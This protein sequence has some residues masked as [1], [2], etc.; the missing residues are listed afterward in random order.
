M[1]FIMRF[2][3]AASLAGAAIAAPA[4]PTATDT[5]D[6]Y[7]AQATARTSSPT[8]HVKGK[9][10]D[11]Y[12][13]IWFEN[14]DFD[15]AAA[16][17]N[18]QFFAEK[19]ITLTNNLALT[20]PSEP[21]YMA[22]VGGDYFG[23]DGDPFIQVPQNVSSVVD[24]LEDKGIS[25]SLYQEDMPYTGFE[26]FAWVNQQ[27]GANDYVRKHNP[28]I[29]YNSV[30]TN[31]DRL[32]NIK[33]TT[34]FYEDLKANKL[35]QWMFITPN[36][37]S[38]GHD[39]SVTVAGQWLRTFLEPLL[40]DKNFMQNTMVLI[41]FDE[42]ETYTIQNRVF[43]VLLG[44][45]VPQELVGTTDSNYYNHYSEISTVEANW[46]LYTLGRWDVGANVFSNV[47]A[48][49]GDR[50]RCW[51]AQPD[52]EHRYFN[53]SYSGIFNS[54]SFAVQPVPD[55]HSNRNFRTTFPAIKKQWEKY[56]QYNY[57]HGQLEIPDGYNPPAV[58]NY[59]T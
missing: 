42:N 7:A 46:G 58:I 50:V 13:S 55:V 48:H 39:T 1:S 52:L 41:T 15:M 11:R 23:L 3:A 27:N 36:M 19:G 10:F 59:S 35:P 44:D 9:A 24:L 47:A 25:W 56:Q 4:S 12:V 18:F 57:Y 40:D 45:A 53:Y 14:T 31:S 17:P 22:A 6:V 8:S 34:L 43:S 2:L 54:K 30:V 37:T 32:S 5:A 16:D 33:N 26:G 28:E 29:L 51:D 21:N 20:H 49:T 38:D